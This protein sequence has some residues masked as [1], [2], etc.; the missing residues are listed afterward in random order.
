MSHKND[1]IVN[2]TS[3]T[4]KAAGWKAWTLFSQI[5]LRQFQL[6]AAGFGS[7][8]FLPGALDSDP[9]CFFPIFHESLLDEPAELLLHE[10]PGGPQRLRLHL[11]FFLKKCKV[12]I[13]LWFSEKD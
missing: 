2:Y 11:M 4:S 3:V 6:H 10:F 13:L 7:R 12:V 5:D 1:Q 9:L 8:G